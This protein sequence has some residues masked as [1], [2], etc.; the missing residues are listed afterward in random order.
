MPV[1]VPKGEVMPLFFSQ[2]LMLMHRCTVRVKL[3]NILSQLD[4][5]RAHAFSPIISL[6][7]HPS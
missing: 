2:K 4:I 1:A 5:Q 3:F 7:L 6:E